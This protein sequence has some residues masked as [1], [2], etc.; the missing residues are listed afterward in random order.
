MKNRIPLELR[1]N[2]SSEALDTFQLCAL[3]EKKNW[4]TFENGI[5]GLN[6]W[7][8]PHTIQHVEITRIPCKQSIISDDFDFL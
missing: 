8:Y 4:Q 1:P 2:W 7:I 3:N 5:C 6:H